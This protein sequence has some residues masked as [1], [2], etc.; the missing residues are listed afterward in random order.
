M[1]DEIES[2]EEKDVYDLVLLPPGRKALRSLWRYNTKFNQNGLVSRW[3]SRLAVD[4][5]R[6]IVEIRKHQ[7]RDTYHFDC[8]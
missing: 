5:S 8:L 7:L 4:G 2:M 6:Q 1:D 3:K